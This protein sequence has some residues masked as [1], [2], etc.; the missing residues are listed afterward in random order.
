MPISISFARFLGL[1]APVANAASPLESDL[2]ALYKANAA[3]TVSFL[4]AR[5]DL[6]SCTEHITY[7][8]KEQLGRGTYGAVYRAVPDAPGSIDVAVKCAFEDP[9]GEPQRQGGELQWEVDIVKSLSHREWILKVLGKICEDGMDC[10]V[11][12]LGGNSLAAQ[13]EKGIPLCQRIEIADRMI[14][15]VKELYTEGISHRDLHM[16]NWLLM[17]DLNAQSLRLIDFAVALRDVSERNTE[18]ELTRLLYTICDLLH[19]PGGIP[20]RDTEMCPRDRFPRPKTFD[21]LD[22][23]FSTLRRSQAAACAS[24]AEE[25]SRTA[26]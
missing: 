12:E 25:G 13:L 14:T 11:F 16:G 24:T 1:V 18:P 26:S 2:C 23:A 4:D 3:S 17:D 6:N 20:E 22:E 15:V 9:F 8:L 21:K 19:F 5:P 10:A 7:H